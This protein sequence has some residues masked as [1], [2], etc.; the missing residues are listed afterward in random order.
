[1]DTGSFMEECSAGLMLLACEKNT[2]GSVDPK[3]SERARTVSAV[4]TAVASVWDSIR[5]SKCS[6]KVL[7]TGH[8][9]DSELPAQPGRAKEQSGLVGRWA[10]STGGLEDAPHLGLN[11]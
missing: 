9:G 3:E 7:S 1:M 8:E 4:V 2:K 5:I 11:S 6:V 10:S